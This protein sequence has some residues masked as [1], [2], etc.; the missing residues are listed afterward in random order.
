MVFKVLV[1]EATTL[2]PK[3]IAKNIICIMKIK[4]YKQILQ[5]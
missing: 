1:L 5:P 2:I 4:N 3:T